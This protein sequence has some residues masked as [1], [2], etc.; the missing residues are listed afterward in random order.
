M[1]FSAFAI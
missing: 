1:T